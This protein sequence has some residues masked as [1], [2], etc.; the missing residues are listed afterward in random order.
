MAATIQQEHYDKHF[1]HLRVADTPKSRFILE[2]DK[3]KNS[4]LTKGTK[5][6]CHH[7]GTKN[8]STNT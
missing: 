4:P 1:I 7:A 6:K 2:K 8:F 5:E 3:S